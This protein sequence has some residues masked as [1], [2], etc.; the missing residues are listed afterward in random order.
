[1]EHTPY[2]VINERKLRRNIKKM[3]EMAKEANVNLRPHIKTHKMPYIAKMQLAEGAVGI[4]VAKI[5]EAKVMAKHGIED[6]FIAYPIV[7]TSKA[8]E[9]CKLNQH[10]PNLIVAADSFV[11][12]KVLN[13]CAQ[14]H[15]Q[16]LQVR[17][18]IDTGLRRT[19]VLY[20]E[21]VSLAQQISKL[22]NLFLQGIFTFKGAVYKGEGTVDTESAGREEGELMVEIARQIR[23]TGIPLADISVGSTPT[24]KSA[25]EV[26]GV[27]EIRPGTYVFNDSMQ[28]KLGVSSWD[29]CAAYVV[30][31]VV[32]KPSTDYVVIDGGSKTFA[33]D[34][35]PNSSPLNLKGFGAVQK[36]TD[37]NFVRMNEEHGILNLDS[38][39]VDIGEE[40]TIIPN[41]ICS[42]VNLHN[43]VFLQKEN[44]EFQKL[45]VEARGLVH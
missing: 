14:K 2:V 39:K 11:G 25:A 12:A 4:T 36:H 34:V 15:N 24:A 43:Y 27:T 3:S 31:T 40:V 26:E 19:G 6:I 9:I 18:E 28:V 41:H 38:S 32:S 1:M 37:A 20:E 5:A 29:E 42:T 13:D 10:L 8:E 7:T 17:L 45:T 21:A 22:D 30:S 33:T 44:N 35:Q 23:A 16:K